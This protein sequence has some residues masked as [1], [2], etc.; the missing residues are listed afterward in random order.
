METRIWT[1]FWLAYF[2]IAGIG[3]GYLLA[4]MALKEKAVKAYEAGR[5]APTPKYR[6]AAFQ[7]G[8]IAWFIVGGV[9][10]SGKVIEVRHTESFSA[11]GWGDGAEIITKDEFKYLLKRNDD[12]YPSVLWVYAKDLFG[13][14]N[15]AADQITRR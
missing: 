13:T 6:E 9:I 4:A 1:I 10:Y 8:D 3:M 11:A 12:S 7:V 14:R 5:M 2:L 15:D